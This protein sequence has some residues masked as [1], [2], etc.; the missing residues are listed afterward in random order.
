[1]G[2]S[3]QEYWSGLPSPP[4]GDFPNPVI[5]PA[6]PE[7]PALQAYYLLLSHR[8]NPE[9]GESSTILNLKHECLSQ[10]RYQLM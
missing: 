6:S 5:K 7:A 9:R 8:V 3:R 4:P 10:Q 1:M 2:F